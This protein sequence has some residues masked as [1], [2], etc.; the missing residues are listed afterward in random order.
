MVES[1]RQRA[2]CLSWKTYFEPRNASGAGYDFRIYFQDAGFANKGF[3]KSERKFVRRVIGLCMGLA[4]V[5]AMW[6]GPT[7]AQV[8]AQGLTPQR[9]ELQGAAEQDVRGQEARA[10]QARFARRVDE[11]LGSEAV[12]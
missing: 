4:G 11:V 2:G 8:G 1:G 3:M 5:A 6:A 10:A 7:F 12:R 9:N